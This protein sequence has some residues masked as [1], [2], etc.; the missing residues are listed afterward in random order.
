[1]NII[2]NSNDNLK[3]T[4]IREGFPSSIE[5]VNAKDSGEPLSWILRDNDNS[6]DTQKNTIHS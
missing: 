3:F 6:K 4:I 1:M 2:N 5:Y